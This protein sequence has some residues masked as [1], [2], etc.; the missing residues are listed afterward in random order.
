MFSVW[1]HTTHFRTQEHSCTIYRTNIVQV[2]SSHNPFKYAVKFSQS[3]S[4]PQYSSIHDKANKQAFRTYPSKITI[5]LFL[6][7]HTLFTIQHPVTTFLPYYY[8]ALN[9]P[10][11][12]LSTSI[13]LLSQTLM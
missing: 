5:L 1:K 11:T 3:L 2:R 7:S 12:F 8:Y 10:I 4:Y 13:V 9:T 6:L